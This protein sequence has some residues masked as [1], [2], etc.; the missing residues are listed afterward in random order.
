MKLTVGN[1]ETAQYA[2]KKRCY[3]PDKAPL[4]EVARIF[5]YINKLNMEIERNQDVYDGMSIDKM[6]MP[7][8]LAQF[9]E[10]RQIKFDITKEGQ[11]NLI[12]YDQWDG[13]ELEYHDKEVA[14]SEDE[15]E[16]LLEELLK[17]NSEATLDDVPKAMVRRVPTDESRRNQKQTCPDWYHYT[18]F[19]ADLEAVQIAIRAK[20]CSNNISVRQAM[21]DVNV[22]TIVDK[23]VV[24]GCVKWDTDVTSAFVPYFVEGFNIGLNPREYQHDVDYM[25]KCM[26]KNNIKEIFSK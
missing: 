1:T 3:R 4:L 14:L 11:I 17:T 24:D 18:D 5:G 20:D 19:L 10:P 23:L 9:L 21:Q 6:M 25:I 15:R 7:S 13:C 2:V 26:L 12:D 22:M 8:G 16:G